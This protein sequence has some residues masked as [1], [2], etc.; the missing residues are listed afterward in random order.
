[1]KKIFA[2]KHL[3]YFY[4]FIISFLIIIFLLSAL[5][6]TIR[7]LYGKELL[8]R[9]S[10][11]WIV[12]KHLWDSEHKM[13]TE[14]SPGIYQTNMEDN[15]G[16]AFQS[17]AMPKKDK[18]RVFCIGGSSTQGFPCKPKDSFPAK[19]QKYLVEHSSQEVE[20]INAGQEAKSSGS[21]IKRIEEVMLYDADCIILYAGHN[22]YGYYFWA[23]EILDTHPLILKID[24]MLNNFYS[25]R[26]LSRF[27]KRDGIIDKDSNNL[28]MKYPRR[29]LSAYTQS[30]IDEYKNSIPLIHWDKFV[31]NEL[32]LC[33]ETFRENLIQMR[34]LLQKANIPFYV[35]TVV[36][37]LKDFPPFISLHRP[38]ISLRDLNKYKKM[39]QEAKNLFNSGLYYRSIEKLLD[40]RKLDDK[41]AETYFLLGKSYLYLNKYELA[42]KNF[43]LAR[44]FSP[45][46]APFQRAPSSLNQIIRT[47]CKKYNIFLID[48]EKEFHSKTIPGNDL[49]SDSL[50]PN[51]LGYDTIA[52]I[53]SRK[54]VIP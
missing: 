38:N 27:L 37:N 30:P 40:L 23:K 15:P 2:K 1:M 31:K 8:L 49:F 50:H 44:D 12:H 11:L 43:I 17:F 36:S 18:F 19:L 22:E 41:Y 42:L 14:T 9:R 20:V 46:Y 13:F 25:Y 48:I 5:E 34:I 32:F 7:A 10:S 47:V 51:E 4:L 39:L 6:I 52:E 33:E 26:L 16:T 3:F 21:F 53:I 29:Q 35:C 28:W 24:L 45:A 54:I